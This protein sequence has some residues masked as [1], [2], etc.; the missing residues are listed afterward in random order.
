MAVKNIHMAR[1]TPHAMI[2]GFDEVR[3]MAN[4][5]PNNTHI[6]MSMIAL[7]IKDVFCVS[8]MLFYS[9]FS[10]KSVN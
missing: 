5:T 3:F 2:G 9:C 1:K 7:I 8:T 4:Q 6:S 10:K